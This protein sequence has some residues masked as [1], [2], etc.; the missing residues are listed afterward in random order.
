VTGSAE[1]GEFISGI[2]EQ[3]SE[4]VFANEAFIGAV[5]QL[6]NSE[7]IEDKTDLILTAICHS[8]STGDKSN[9]DIFRSVHLIWPGVRAN[10]LDVKRSLTVG[11]EL[12][13]ISTNEASQGETLW[14]LTKDGVDDIQRHEKWVME[15][16]LRAKQ[17]IK[18]RAQSDFALE[19]SDESSGLILE[20]LISLLI[21]GIQK[22]QSA[23]LGN[24][25]E[26]FGGNVRPIKIDQSLVLSGMERSDVK[27]GTADFIKAL[28]LM[29]ID[30]LEPFGNEIVSHITI[31]CILHS[32]ICGRD[33]ALIIEKVGD[34]VKERA[35]LD[36]PILL[37]M[38]G[39]KILAACI[40]E[41]VAIA[42]KAG[43]EVIVCDHYLAELTELLEK[44][45]PEIELRYKQVEKEGIEGSWV[46]AL[47]ADRLPTMCIEVIRDGT[48]SNL[49]QMVT[50][51]KELGK[52]LTAIGLIV[53]SADNYSD[54]KYVDKCLEALLAQFE[55]RPK[56]RSALAMQR[57]ADSM[58]L[59]WRRRR[60]QIPDSKW[61]G[62]WII[63][64]DR[65]MNPAFIKAQYP[66]RIPLTLTF[67]EWTNLL[68]LSAPPLTVV[69]LA[70]VAGEQIVKEAMFGIPARYTSDSALA[71]AR[72]IN[73]NNLGSSVDV[74]VAQMTLDELLQE[75]A[76][77]PN[78]QTIS[79]AI[80]SKRSLRVDKFHGRAMRRKDEEVNFAKELER[81]T[82]DQIKIDRA[83]SDELKRI[84][85]ETKNSKSRLEIQVNWYRKKIRRILI[86]AILF[87]VSVTSAIL[88]LDYKDRFSI[89]LFLVSLAV[90]SRVMVTWC[91]QESST[92]RRLIWPSLF[93]ILGIL[94][95]GEWLLGYMQRL[96]QK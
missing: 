19:I 20:R 68:A 83:D 91:T 61:P 73:A 39:S 48:Y 96:R 92:W 74:R 84:L 33:S 63:S 88:F 16:K 8:L 69:E 12:N 42:I 79:A 43:W 27:E 17:D 9:E 77:L 67:A 25:E 23:Y 21:V 30:P 52:R 34:P 64:P 49:R 66:D 54:Q 81:K 10:L 80:L 40:F 22:S 62:A 76:V 24:V 75:H 36:T 70:K 7:R 53:R 78:D 50:A 3:R 37:G 51:S 89:V 14:H 13:L 28:A 59:A 5:H 46:A 86:S 95:M 2:S 90:L 35:I 72:Q 85:E 4:I 55:G 41:A 31:G 18:D 71:I 29:A 6:T 47:T 32:Y 57:D 58:S 87:L 38:V 45:I 82:M 15:V 94:R 65:Q 93:E 1:E 44:E 11:E 56:Q 26:I 60:N